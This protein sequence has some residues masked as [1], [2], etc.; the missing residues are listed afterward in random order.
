MDFV[1]SFLYHKGIFHFISTEKKKRFSHI[2]QRSKA[3]TKAIVCV[4]KSWA[5]KKVEIIII[6]QGKGLKNPNS[7]F[8][9]FSLC[10]E[11]SL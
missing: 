8:S 10:T 7:Y 4:C 6:K 1:E 11:Q 2:T 3:N 5:E 9:R